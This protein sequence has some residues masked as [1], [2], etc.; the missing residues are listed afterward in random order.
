MLRAEP[1]QRKDYFRIRS[2]TAQEAETMGKAWV[3]EGY[4]VARDGKTLISADG[5][6]VYRP[7]SYKPS[8]GKVQANFEQRV[9]GQRSGN[10]ISNAHLDIK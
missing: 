5:L 4:K 8:L 10:P 7:P 1:Q 9:S 3:G 6:R 2:A